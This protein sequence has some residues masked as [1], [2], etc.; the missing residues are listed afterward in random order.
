[1]S[2]F[3]T[4]VSP[5]KLTFQ[6]LQFSANSLKHFIQN[7]SSPKLLLSRCYIFKMKCIT[8][9]IQPT[10]WTIFV[11]Q[12]GLCHR[13]QQPSLHY[14]LLL[15]KYIQ[16]VGYKHPSSEVLIN[17]ILTYVHTMFGSEVETGVGNLSQPIVSSTLLCAIQYW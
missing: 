11:H 2:L 10:P 7:L 1:M 14:S 3:A 17:N 9:N 6:T 15:H 13:A 16:F 8:M 5:W 12:P 4:H